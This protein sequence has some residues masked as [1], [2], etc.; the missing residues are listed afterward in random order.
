MLETLRIGIPWK[1]AR[2]PHTLLGR[3][4]AFIMVANRYFGL[5]DLGMSLISSHD[6]ESI[7]NASKSDF[8]P[9]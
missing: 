3:E 1:Q 6:L 8:P 4:V 5:I 2:L 9:L 7:L